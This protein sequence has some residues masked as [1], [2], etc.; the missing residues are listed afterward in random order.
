ME[1]LLKEVKKALENEM[2]I[3]ALTLGLTIPDICGNIEYPDLKGPRKCMQRYTRWYDEHI[4][5]YNKSSEMEDRSSRMT[6]GESA[7]K[8]R[9]AILHSFDISEAEKGNTEIHFNLFKSKVFADLEMEVIAYI[10]KRFPNSSFKYEL[11]AIFSSK[12]L[13]E[14]LNSKLD[15]GIS[16]YIQINFTNYKVLKPNMDVSFSLEQ[17]IDL[18]EELGH[19]VKIVIDLDLEDN[20]D[21][22]LSWDTNMKI[23][24]LNV[25][26]FVY[27]M[28]WCAEEYYKKNKDKADVKFPDIFINK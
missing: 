26:Q 4:T 13:D 25:P 5:E 3:S 11:D 7:Y 1:E 16:T 18:I 19:N 8:I 10:K 15:T 21:F 23:I 6:S 28:L 17:D 22:G 20:Y 12:D 14:K 9:C 2:Y 24:S 27:P